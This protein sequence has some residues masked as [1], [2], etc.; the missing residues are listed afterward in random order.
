MVTKYGLVEELWRLLDYG[1]EEVSDRR[2]GSEDED[3]TDEED[4]AG[5]CA[6]VAV[7]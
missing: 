6:H 3:D 5:H 1:D 2:G 7:V 4:G